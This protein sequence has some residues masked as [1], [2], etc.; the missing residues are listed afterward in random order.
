MN[1]FT[2]SIMPRVERYLFE[3][4]SDEISRL[5]HAEARRFA[6]QRP[7][8]AVASALKIYCVAL[9]RDFEVT[10][11]EELGIPTLPEKDAGVASRIA[12]RRPLPLYVNHQVDIILNNF[13]IE[14]HRKA[15]L[16]R[17][18][19]I[20]FKRDA[21]S[22][23]YEVFLTTFIL[24]EILEHAHQRQEQRCAWSEGTVRLL[25]RANLGIR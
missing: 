17:L 23:W 1:D 2:E 13:I 5:I 22:V 3:Q 11:G 16:K 18:N 8:S 7:E 9:C 24:L 19:G 4:T 14:R 21:V 20:I 15:V 25:R 10:N 12:G 6:N